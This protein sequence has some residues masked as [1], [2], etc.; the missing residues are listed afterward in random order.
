[1]YPEIEPIDVSALAIERPEA[2]V[3]DQDVDDMLET[4]RQQRKIWDTVERKAA[5][6]ERALIEYSAD[7]DE[8]RVPAEGVQRVAILMG[9]SGLE[10]LEQAVA[11]LDP[12][13]NTSLEL[14][15]PE[16]FREPKLAGRTARTELKLVSVSEGRLPEVDE[17]FIKS[18]GVEDGRLETLKEEIRNNLA[19]ELKQAVTTLL[20]TQLVDQLLQAR[21]DLEVPD[22][23]VREEAT[24]MAAQVTRGQ[25]EQPDPRVVQAFM[26][27]ARARVRAGL[28]MGEL[29]N[30]NRIRIDGTKVRATIETIANTYE[31]P[32]EVMQLY[33]GNQ[34]LMQQVESSVL[35]EQVV[36]WVLE[37]AKVTPKGMK[38]QEVI[39]S[40]TQAAKQG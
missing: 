15:Y 8:G 26:D 12:G 25:G 4:L 23:V 33:Y 18:Y 29:A 7:T 40:A 30:Q 2:A 34:R 14:A 31:Q 27:Q 22:S 17:A 3:R 20:K 16:N 32:A 38:F 11:A 39:T 6:G 13:A 37:N 21:P 9:D 5:A 35:E 1:V 24:G 19:R 10:A 28:L 36:D